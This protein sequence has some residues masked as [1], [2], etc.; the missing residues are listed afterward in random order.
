M[1]INER[2]YWEN[3]TTEGHGHDENLAKGILD[4]ISDETCLYE[5]EP[6]EQ[7]SVIDIGCGDGFYTRYLKDYGIDCEGYDGNPF[8]KELTNGIC[9]VVDFSL[10]NANE[11]T[12]FRTYDWV[13]SLEVGEHI[14]K[15]F[16]QI[17][18]DNIISF[19]PKVIILSWSIPEYGGDGHVNSRPN[20]YII[21][22][23]EKRNY[24]F[25]V[26]STK[27]LRGY[28]AKYPYPCYWFS[29]TLMIFRKNND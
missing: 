18:L 11:R 7:I 13:L 8:T 28:P 2:G 25:D 12:K 1:K 9:D 3:D 24:T 10:P 6:C 15:E 16:E 21:T 23:I 26:D 27:F 17:F 20:E 19:L 4:F 29:K 5:D 22:E 14:P